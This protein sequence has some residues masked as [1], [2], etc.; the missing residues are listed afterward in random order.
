MWLRTTCAAVLLIS[1]AACSG[2]GIGRQYE[3]EEEVYLDTDGSA[4]VVVNS[5]LPALATLHGLDVPLDA[6]ARVD[7]GRIRSLYESA[8]TDVLRVSRPWR[9]KGRRFIQ[10][11]VEV[12]DIRRLGEAAPFAWSKYGFDREQGLA[13][14]RQ[15]VGTPAERRVSFDGWDG[16]ELV[17][18][19]LHVPS[20]I[21]Y[22]NAPS[23][24]VERG[25]ILEWQQPLR[26]RLGGAPVSIEVRMT[27][28]SILYRT[29]LLFGATLTAALAL[30]AGIVWW[31]WRKGRAAMPPG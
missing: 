12:S 4:T 13:V 16:S 5:S 9:K 7:R 18:F 22:H 20:R 21:V 10:V 14:F 29:L 26:E 19:R 25:N 28:V 1:A 6:G 11:R 2:G 3:Y 8:V 31:V 15:S 23:K 27:P 30:L 17:A 24:R